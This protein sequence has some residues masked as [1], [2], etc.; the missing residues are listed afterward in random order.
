MYKYITLRLKECKCINNDEP[1]EVGM[2]YDYFELPGPKYSWEYK[3]KERPLYC[4]I[5]RKNEKDYYAIYFDYEFDEVFTILE[6]ENDNKQIETKVVENN[7]NI[8]IYR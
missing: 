3:E 8:N 5:Y 6:S 1:F 2:V 4:V 7:D